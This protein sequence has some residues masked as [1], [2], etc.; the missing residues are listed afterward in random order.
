MRALYMLYGSIETKK[1]FENRCC[2]NN[3]LLKMWESAKENKYIT[4]LYN[5][6]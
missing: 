5:A 3:V 2:I 4:I 6:R 1:D